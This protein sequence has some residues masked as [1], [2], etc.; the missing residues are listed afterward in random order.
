[1]FNHLGTGVVLRFI[2]AAVVSIAIA[3]AAVASDHGMYLFGSAELRSRSFDPPEQWRRVLRLLESEQSLY[4]ACRGE[5]AHCPDPAV[6]HWIRYLQKLVGD[7][8]MEQ[9]VAVNRY[10]NQWR[11]RTDWE[12]FGRSDYWATPSE[13]LHSSG[14]CED[15]AIT[16]YVSLRRLGFAA[17]SVRLVVLRDSRRN[18]AHAVLAV[19]VGDKVYILDN[20]NDSVLRHEAIR[21]Y[22]PYYSLNEEARWTHL[23]GRQT[24][25]LALDPRVLR[26]QVVSGSE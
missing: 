10:V 13:F 17:E 4:E 14:D 22:R 19:R 24:A 15:Y 20:L 23:A 21:N 11:Y 18:L 16:K 1:M 8:A 7:T 26:G 2:L 6:R 12:T 9:V 5:E 25:L 3:G